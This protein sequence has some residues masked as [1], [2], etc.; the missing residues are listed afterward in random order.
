MAPRSRTRRTDAAEDAGT[1]P[2]AAQ[3]AAGDLAVGL[4]PDV[5]VYDSSDPHGYPDKSEG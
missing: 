5:L 3:D 4:L 2:D 1:D